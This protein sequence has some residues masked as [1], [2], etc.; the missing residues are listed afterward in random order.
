MHHVRSSLTL[1]FNNYVVSSLLFILLVRVHSELQSTTFPSE[2]RSRSC[3]GH[4]E[5]FRS[6]RSRSKLFC[7]ARFCETPRR[8][9]K[10][11]LAGFAC[12]RGSAAFLQHAQH[13][14]S[15]VCVTTQ[16]AQLV[17]HFALTSYGTYGTSSGET[18]RGRQRGPRSVATRV[19]R[20]AR[21]APF[22]TFYVKT[23]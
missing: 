5:T 19:V 12:E 22:C 17:E 14:T 23:F 7:L 16:R 21:T 10:P 18:H 1:F 3:R 6:S 15:D 9:V 13:G 8:V 4:S 20:G 2:L 11:D